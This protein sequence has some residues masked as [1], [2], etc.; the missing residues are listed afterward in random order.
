MKKWMVVGCCLWIFTAAVAE[1]SVAVKE[2]IIALEKEMAVALVKTDVDTL[3]RLWAAD[4]M[5][6]NPGNTV[7]TNRDQVLG[8]VHAG[9]IRYD[10]FEQKIEEIRV[11]ENLVMV[12][13]EEIVQPSDTAPGAGLTLHRR[14]TCALQVFG[15]WVRGWFGRRP[16][17]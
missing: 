4:F 7:L 10:R 1:E 5:V 8:R 14:F 12:M 9:I 6:N 13:G 15:I 11:Y 3:T 16:I 2:Q 17:L